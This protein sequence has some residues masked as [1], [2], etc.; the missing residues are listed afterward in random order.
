MNNTKTILIVDDNEG[1][2]VAL[3]EALSDKYEVF[4]AKEGKES[5]DI[6]TGREVDLIILDIRLPG[7]N[8]LEILREIRRATAG[9]LVIVITAYNVEKEFAGLLLDGKPDGFLK[10]PLDLSE[11][12]EKISQLIRQKQ[13]R[14]CEEKHSVSQPFLDCIAEHVQHMKDI[15]RRNCSKRIRLSDVEREI[16]RSPV[17]LS[18]IFK[19]VTGERFTNFRVEENIK[20]ARELILKYPTR[21]IKQ[22]ARRVGY[23]DTCYFIKV[24]KKLTGET[25]GQFRKCQSQRKF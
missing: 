25:P 15:V 1:V 4:C 5:L 12:T 9:I 20:K 8:G 3:S 16:C 7:M 24:F 21:S 22:I 2:R 17:Y 18:R 10:K 6:I 11:V 23:K 19:R 14:N 13:D